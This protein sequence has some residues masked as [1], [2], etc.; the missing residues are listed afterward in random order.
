MGEGV[1]E[2]VLVEVGAIKEAFGVGGDPAAGFGMVVAAA[3]V[4]EVGDF[5]FGLVA[6]GVGGG[7]ELFVETGE[8]VLFAEG[9]VAVGFVEGDEGW[10]KWRG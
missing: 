5:A 8:D 4:D 3:E 7:D 1:V 2:G 9:G 6:P 10:R